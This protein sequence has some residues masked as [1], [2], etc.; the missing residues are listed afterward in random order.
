M[1]K[2]NASEG[3]RRCVIFLKE[4]WMRNGQPQMQEKSCLMLQAPIRNAERMFAKS[5]CV[6]PLTVVS[7][8]TKRRLCCLRP[9]NEEKKFFAHSVQQF[10]CNNYNRAEHSGIEQE[11]YML[12]N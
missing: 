4:I 6:S 5:R 11:L 3:H 8:A 10:V 2:W 12:F 9:G 1:T 7:P